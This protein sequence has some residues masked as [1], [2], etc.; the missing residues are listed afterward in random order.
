MALWLPG[1]WISSLP[2]MISYHTAGFAITMVSALQLDDIS[3][4]A[5]NERVRR[6]TEKVRITEEMS[7]S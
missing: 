7:S 6:E 2:N 1:V 4:A 3:R 5:E